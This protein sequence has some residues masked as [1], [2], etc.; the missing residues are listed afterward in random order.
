LYLHVVITSWRPR[1]PSPAGAAP[2][3]SPRPGNLGNEEGHLPRETEAVGAQHL[4]GRGDA[5]HDLRGGGD[6]PLRSA[7]MI[8]DK[9]LSHAS[10]QSKHRITRN[11]RDYI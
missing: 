6:D 4:G 3:R 11:G 5:P 1:A 8:D 2:R 10:S 9:A 7:L